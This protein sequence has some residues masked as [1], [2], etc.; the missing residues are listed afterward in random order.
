M[1]NFRPITLKYREWKY[2]YVESFECVQVAQVGYLV[3]QHQV[4]LAD[5]LHGIAL[6]VDFVADEVDGAICSIGNQLDVLIL[7]LLWGGLG[8]GTGGVCGRLA[9]RVL[10]V[11][12]LP[13]GGAA[14][15]TCPAAGAVLSIPVCCQVIT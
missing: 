8:G 5:L 14:R 11:G 10:R 3:A 1:F 15:S 2:K 13:G 12:G 4:V 9:R 6:L 7:L